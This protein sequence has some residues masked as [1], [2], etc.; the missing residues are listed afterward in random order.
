MG[1][2]AACNVCNEP[3]VIHALLR[4]PGDRRHVWDHS[5][6]DR[7]QLDCSTIRD[8]FAFRQQNVT[9]SQKI[10]VSVKNVFSSEFLWLRINFG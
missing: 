1:V 7:R 8:A 3:V 6:D 9:I 2:S 5:A 10:W 4:E